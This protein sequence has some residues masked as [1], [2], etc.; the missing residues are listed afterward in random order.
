MFQ[1][2]LTVP[3]SRFTHNPA[4]LAVSE[5]KM[6]DSAGLVDDLAEIEGALPI[7]RILTLLTL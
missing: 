5:F 3:V 2:P 4:F 1:C 7:H 6:A